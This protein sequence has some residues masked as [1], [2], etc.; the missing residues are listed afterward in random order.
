MLDLDMLDIENWFNEHKY[1]S[2]DEFLEALIADEKKWKEE[3]EED[4]GLCI[5]DHLILYISA[6]DEIYYQLHKK[7]VDYF[8]LREGHG[9]EQEDVYAILLRIIKTGESFFAGYLEYIKR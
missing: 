7:P 8:G 9:L 6:L 5:D 3:N 4:G 1:A 2:I